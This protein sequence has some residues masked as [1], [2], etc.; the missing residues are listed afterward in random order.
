MIADKFHKKICLGFT[1]AMRLK[2]EYKLY[3]RYPDQLA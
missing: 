3:G 1:K 2:N